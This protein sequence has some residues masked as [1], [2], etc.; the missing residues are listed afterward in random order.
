[1]NKDS[2]GLAGRTLVEFALARKWVETWNRASEDLER[3][4]RKE[5]R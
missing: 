2:F 3:I 5:L 1:M 4:R